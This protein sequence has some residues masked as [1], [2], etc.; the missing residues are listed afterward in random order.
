MK[1]LI[2]CHFLLF[3]QT[4]L[5]ETLLFLSVSYITL[6][7]LQLHH[8]SVT[9]KQDAL[10]V[11]FKMLLMNL[12]AVCKD[13]SRL[14]SLMVTDATSYNVWVSTYCIR[15]EITAPLCLSGNINQK[16]KFKLPIWHGCM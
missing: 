2:S 6:T 16:Y 8:K 9:L 13:N 15:S 10:G 5:G 3:L 1:L 14:Q 12:I 7:H 4:Y 11:Y